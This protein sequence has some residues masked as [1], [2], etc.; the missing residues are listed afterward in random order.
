MEKPTRTYVLGD[1]IVDWRPELCVHCMA[2]HNGLPQVFDPERK[3]W[4][5][6]DAAPADAIK[7]QVAQ[8]P[9]G[10]LSLGDEPG[11]AGRAYL[12]AL[13]VGKA[14]SLE[15]WQVRVLEEYRELDERLGK[16]ATYVWSSAFQRLALED[17]ELLRDQLAAM[18]TYYN[19]LARRIERW[20]ACPTT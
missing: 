9:S 5:K 13:A 17:Q 8:C 18:S 7:A 2:C 16:L 19:I 3:P 20:P 4:V 10:A 6:L 12:A 11:N 14:T 15:P 1:L